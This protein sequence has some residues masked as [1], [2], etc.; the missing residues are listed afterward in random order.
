MTPMTNSRSWILTALA[1]V[2]LAPGNGVAPT[3]PASMRQ[4]VPT[5]SA[6]RG[7]YETE[8]A[9]RMAAERHDDL[10]VGTNFGIPESTVWARDPATVSLVEGHTIRSIGDAFKGYALEQLGIDRWSFPVAGRT[11]RSGHVAVSGPTSGVR[12]R[13]GVS[14]LAPRADL[15]IPTSAGRVALS[16]DARGRFQ[17]TFEPVS[18]RLRFAADAD[19]PARTASVALSAQF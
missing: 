18:S 8:L 6:H 5:F 12:L 9:P 15:L 19:V 2:V 16:V 10:W 4:P 14:H 11:G 3:L 1:L 17:A 7:F 13:F